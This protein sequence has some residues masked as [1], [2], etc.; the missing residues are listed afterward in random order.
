MKNLKTNTKNIILIT[1]SVVLAILC[2]ASISTNFLLADKY[3]TAVTSKPMIVYQVD[4]TDNSI[5][6]VITDKQVV[7]NRYLLTINGQETYMVPKD[8]Y[9]ANKIGDNVPLYLNGK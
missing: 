2:T 3:K 6:G 8:I 9:E 5:T 7:G 1:I 4:S